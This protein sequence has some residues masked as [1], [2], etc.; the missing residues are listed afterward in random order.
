MK[1]YFLISLF[2]IGMTG[3]VQASTI[4]PGRINNHNGKEIPLEEGGRRLRDF[5]LSLDVENL[6]IAG[7]HINW[8]TGMADRPDVTSGNHT[9]CSA[10][11][12]AACKKLNIY[13]LRPPE[14]K[15]VLL[16]NAQFE[17]L[18]G[19]DALSEGWR[20]VTGA[21]PYEA[22]QRL[23]NK[24]MV[25]VAICQNPDPAKPGHAALVM[26]AALTTEKM[27]E[28]GPVCIMAGTHNFNKIS[29]RNGFRSHLTGWP[30]RS[31]LFYYNI[32]LP[33]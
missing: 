14:H 22:A 4:P 9:H 20:L 28:S 12:A 29:L 7:Q 10:F 31:I 24:G 33:G 21:D 26:P 16:A 19:S 5:Y 6:W 8:E 11:V 18:K 27:E 25:V 32:H 1:R 30:E 13:I 23:A 17:W 15:Q 3:S 2:F